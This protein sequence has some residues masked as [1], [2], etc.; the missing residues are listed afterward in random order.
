MREIEAAGSTVCSKFI[1]LEV[2]GKL[3]DYLP[4]FLSSLRKYAAA[5]VLRTGSKKQSVSFSCA[6]KAP[7]WMNSKGISLFVF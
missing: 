2:V 6:L 4:L 1:F 7:K 3:I 5:A